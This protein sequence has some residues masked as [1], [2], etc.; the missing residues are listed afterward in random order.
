[1]IW[2]ATGGFVTHSKMSGINGLCT[3]VNRRGLEQRPAVHQGVHASH[4]VE[5]DHHQRGR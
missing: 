4:G 5:N 3:A 1:M 2:A